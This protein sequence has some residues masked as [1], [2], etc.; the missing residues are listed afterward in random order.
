MLPRLDLDRLGDRRGRDF[1]PVNV[2]VRPRDGGDL[3][4]GRGNRL[5]GDRFLVGPVRGD[6]HVRDPVLKFGVFQND[7]VRTLLHLHRLGQGGGS[8]VIAVDVHLGPWGCVYFYEPASQHPRLRRRWSFYRLGLYDRFLDRWTGGDRG[9]FLH[10]RRFLRGRRRGEIGLPGSAVFNE[11]RLIGNRRNFSPFGRQDLADHKPQELSIVGEPV[12]RK[13]S[14]DREHDHEHHAEQQRKEYTAALL[15]DDGN[16][17]RRGSMVG[18]GGRGRSGGGGFHLLGNGVFPLL[19]YLLELGQALPGQLVL[20]IEDD[21]LGERVDRI[22]DALTPQVHEFHAPFEILLDPLLPELLPEL[23]GVLHELGDILAGHDQVFLLRIIIDFLEHVP[24]GEVA[25]VD[26]FFERAEEHLL[27]LRGHVGNEVLDRRRGL[28]EDLGDDRRVPLP[29]E[30]LGPGDHLVK[31]HAGG[32]H[33]AALVDLAAGGLLGRHVGGRSHQGPGYGQ[34]RLAARLCQAEIGDFR[35][36]LLGD[37]NV[38]RLDVT[39]DDPLGVGVVQALEDLGD[40]GDRDRERQHLGLG[41]EVLERLAVHE[42]HRDKVD[43]ALG[44]EVDHVDDVLV[45]QAGRALGLPLEAEDEFLILGQVGVQLLDRHHPVERGLDRLVER[46]HPAPPD[47]VLDLKVSDYS[48]H[49]KP[50]C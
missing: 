43:L 7:P 48:C 11:K 49:V 20:G 25:A 38:A 3:E 45:L 28:G 44:P 32:K 50:V 46:S 12:V 29:L 23:L 42:L 47:H 1:F 37:E 30:R 17:G 15:L 21:H 36:S 22:V 13:E 40:N 5:Q 24:G 8:R 16:R 33:I 41:D 6:V 18:R 27:D 10:R 19:F 4:I 9:F 35:D 31:H 2:D 26:V 34:G 14:P 39:V